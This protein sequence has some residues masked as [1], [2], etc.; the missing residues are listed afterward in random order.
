MQQLMD[1]Y[2]VLKPRFLSDQ[3]LG[4]G[5]DA[6]GRARTPLS[7]H[8]LH[9]NNPRS[10]FQT[11]RPISNSLMEAVTSFVTRLHRTGRREE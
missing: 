4:K 8:P 10:G 7:G 1:Y 5:D 11:L 2:E 6:S 9:P 3:V